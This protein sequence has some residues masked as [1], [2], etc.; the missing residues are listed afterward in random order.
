MDKYQKY[1]PG[2]V[3]AGVVVLFV[4]ASLVPIYQLRLGSN[5]QAIFESDDIKRKLALCAEVESQIEEVSCQI[6]VLR[7]DGQLQQSAF[8]A[9][10][11]R[12]SAAFTKGLMLAGFVGLLLSGVG[13]Y[14]IFQTFR[15][16]RNLA[17]DT[18]RIGEAQVRPYLHISDLSVK[19]TRDGRLVF[20]L[21]CKNTGLSPAYDVIAS[22]GFDSSELKLGTLYAEFG[23]LP[24]Q[25]EFTREIRLKDELFTGEKLEYD[26]TIAVDLVLFYRSIF[27]SKN[28]LDGYFS[29]RLRVLNKSGR[30]RA[31]I[32][33]KPTL[34]KGYINK[35]C[36]LHLKAYEIAKEGD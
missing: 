18:R 19:V 35:R 27:S 2:I 30:L 11:Q 8:L 20:A 32:G 26:K 34:S 29:Y 24:S 31:A 10:I 23:T 36:L 33:H 16:T 1:W 22:L 13:I 15:E 28:G 14:L 7:S 4:I 6:E 5:F 3:V 25:T 21:K 9:R 12:D 17:A